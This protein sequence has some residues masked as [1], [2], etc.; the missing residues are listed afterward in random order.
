MADGTPSPWSKKRAAWHQDAAR[1]EIVESHGLL[2]NTFVVAALFFLIVGFTR[3]G[4]GTGWLAFAA[5]AACGFSFWSLRTG[6]A[7]ARWFGAGLA[8]LFA[9]GNFAGLF[10]A[11]DWAW[12]EWVWALFLPFLWGAVAYDLLKPSAR[13]TFERARGE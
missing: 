10:F 8:L 6:R 11:D 1:T 2:L 4:Q 5:A 13:S 3:L 12:Y 9:L 7:W